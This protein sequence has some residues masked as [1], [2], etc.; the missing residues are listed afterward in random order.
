[1]RQSLLHCVP[2]ERNNSGRERVELSVV[3]PAFNEAVSVG[4]SVTELRTIFGLI[5]CDPEIIVVDDGSKD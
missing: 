2:P 3:I 5:G 4:E 1:M